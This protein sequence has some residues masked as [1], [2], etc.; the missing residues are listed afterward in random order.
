MGAV[1]EGL[2]KYAH[3]INQDF[4]GDL[5]EALKDLIARLEIE[6]NLDNGN[7]G[8]E[9]D[10]DGNDEEL[11]ARQSTREVLLCTITAFA[12]LEGQDASKAASSLHLDLS[13]FITH[14]YRALYPLSINSDIEYNP[15]KALRLPDPGTRQQENNN[16]L[17]RKNK[18]NFQTPMVLLLRCLQS[19]LLAR[20]HGAV[21]PMRLAGFT[22]RLMTTALQL[23]EK[24]SIAML[25]LLGKV[26][27]QHGRKVAPLWNTEERK[28]DGVFNPVAVDVEQSNVFAGTVWEGELLRLHYCPEVR[29]A[30]LDIDKLIASTGR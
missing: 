24:S 5:L 8:N 25:A 19:T 7:D 1:L 13:F 12:L 10:E 29:D 26:A 3:L 15:E 14:L 22:K 16:Q 6:D 17:Q 27:K 18:V 11:T 30:A 4:F 9:G 23:P 20:G 28:G 21:P 2:A